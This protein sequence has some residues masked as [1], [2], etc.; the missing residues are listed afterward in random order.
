MKVV[1]VGAKLLHLYQILDEQGPDVGTAPSV[2]ISIPSQSVPGIQIS[3]PN[4]QEL[5]VERDK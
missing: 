4:R 1:T 5:S 2:E 3:A